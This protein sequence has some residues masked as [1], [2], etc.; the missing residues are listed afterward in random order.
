MCAFTC[1]PNQQLTTFLLDPPFCWVVHHPHTRHYRRVQQDMAATPERL[2]VRSLS[3]RHLAAIAS[4]ER[5]G[6]TSFEPAPLLPFRPTTPGPPAGKRSRRSFGS[7][8]ASSG[9][10]MRPYRRTPGPRAPP[11]P[12]RR[13]SCIEMYAPIQDPEAA[14]DARGRAGVRVL[15]P[16]P[17][18]PCG[19]RRA[20]LPNHGREASFVAPG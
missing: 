3:L 8:K 7:G 1:S 18:V 13:S 9:T 14:T 19:G 5:P 6:P 12:G 20:N 11:A 4:G 16:F 15:E 2:Q 17:L 10:R